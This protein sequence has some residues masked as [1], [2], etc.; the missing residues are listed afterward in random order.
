MDFGDSD[1]DREE[2]NNFQFDCG[3]NYEE[4]EGDEDIEQENIIYSPPSVVYTPIFGETL[5]ST[6]LTLR[7]GNSD[8]RDELSNGVQALEA[9][10]ES[11]NN[12]NPTNEGRKLLQDPNEGSDTIC[13]SSQTAIRLFNNLLKIKEGG[14]KSSSGLP[15]FTLETVVS[16]LIERN[17]PKSVYRNFLAILNGVVVDL[18]CNLK[19]VTH[20][21]GKETQKVSQTNLK[22]IL[23][24]MKAFKEHEIRLSQ[25]CA[26]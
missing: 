1:D 13:P 24:V 2:R 11:Y 17:N 12:S 6:V 7:S 14:D 21:S 8:A 26:K 3:E 10:I 9:F 23:Q 5:E 18:S 15:S 16:Y 25:L 20:V 4:E 19:E 22:S